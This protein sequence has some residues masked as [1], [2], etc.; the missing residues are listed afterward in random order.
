[1][2][3]SG[4]PPDRTRTAFRPQDSI[5]RAD[6]IDQ[7]FRCARS[8]NRTRTAFRP[9]DFRTN[10]RFCGQRQAVCGLDFLFT[11]FLAN[12]GASRQVSTPSSN[13]FEAWLGITISALGQKKGFPEFEKFYTK[14]FLLSTQISFVFRSIVGRLTMT[15]GA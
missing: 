2:P 8:G 5:K 7:L 13:Y 6:R 9:Q 12:V 10:Y 15:I 1:M 3:P 14:S 11:L 4:S